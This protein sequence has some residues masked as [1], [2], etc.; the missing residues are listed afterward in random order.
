MWTVTE[1]RFKLLGK[2]QRYLKYLRKLIIKTGKRMGTEEVP[3]G[4]SRSKASGASESC[5]MRISLQGR[6][7][8]SDHSCNPEASK[9]QPG[10]VLAYGG[11]KVQI[12]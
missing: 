8:F 10:N 9:W 7:P 12:H 2:I 5:P 1:Y 6:N 4:R 3:A 11:K